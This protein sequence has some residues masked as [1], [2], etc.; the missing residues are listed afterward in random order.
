MCK[1]LRLNHKAFEQA[2]ESS[3]DLKKTMKTKA[4]AERIAKEMNEQSV[5]VMN[6]QLE[7]RA[8]AIALEMV[9]KLNSQADCEMKV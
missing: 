4:E 8:R 7:E 9:A 1:Q 2:L 5:A 3:L 6:A